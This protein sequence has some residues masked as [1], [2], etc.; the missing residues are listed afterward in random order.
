MTSRFAHGPRIAFV[1]TGAYF[2]LASAGD[3]RHTAATGISTR[4]V[5]QHWRQI[6]TNFVIAETHA[7]FLHRAGRFYAAHFLSQ[8]DQSSTTIEQVTSDDERQARAILRQHDDHD[9]SYTDATSFAVMNRLG[10]RAAFTFD[11][12]FAEYGLNVL[13]PR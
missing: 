6:T 12:N 4:L 7:L 11:R 2:A 10:T 3:I 9:F 8:L 1:D 5:R 13:T